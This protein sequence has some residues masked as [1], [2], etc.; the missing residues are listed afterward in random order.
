MKPGRVRRGIILYMNSLRI[1]VLRGGPSN[2]YDVSLKTGATLLKHIPERH[3]KKD[4]FIGRDGQWHMNGIPTDVERVA[5]SVDLVL[6]ALHGTYGEDG[7]VQ[8]LLHEYKIPFTGSDAIA[9]S[10]G[11]QKH[12]AQN[13]FKKAGLKTPQHIVYRMD[14]DIDEFVRKLHRSFAPPWIIKPAGSGSSVG[15]SIAKTPLDVPYALEKALFHSDVVLAEEFIRGREAT[16]GVIDHFRDQDHYVLLPIEI[17]H[18][19]SFF[20]YNAKYGGNTR[21]ISPGHFSQKEKEEIMHLAREAHKVIGA[22]DYSRSDFIV[23]KR[24]VYILEINTLPG[25]TEHS[26]IPKALEAVGCSMPHFIDHL[27]ERALSRRN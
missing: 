6:N 17:V 1:G 10:L 4:I 3:V 22:R 5:R 12:L 2:E 7:K 26:L 27:V 18:D 16:C 20:D 14:E 15:I 9:S 8:K 21:E 25:L 19:T 11:F 13:A 24:G 23:S